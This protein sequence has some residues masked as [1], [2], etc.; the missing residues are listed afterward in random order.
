MPMESPREILACVGRNG[1]V[2]P[3]AR[4]HV[5]RMN[6]H[7]L[8]VRVLAF[9]P[10]GEFLVQRRSEAKESCPGA[11]TDSA[12]GHVSFRMGL[13]FDLP[14]GLEREAIREL[15][16]EVGVSVTEKDGPLI[17]PFSRPSY[18]PGASE[19]SHCFVAAVSG[20]VR[21]SKEV[22]PI[23]TGFVP[24]SD[25]ERMLVEETFV[26]VAKAYW[27]ELLD[28][29]GDCDPLRFFFKDQGR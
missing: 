23:R 6:I 5:H 1:G 12:S 20:E 27:Q 8:V 28:V 22:D 17:Q 7:H 16:E 26:P 25:L 9:N 3:L 19:T 15:N 13:L 2:F 18:S 10:R 14:H 21:P 24:R 29:I 11:Y 4:E